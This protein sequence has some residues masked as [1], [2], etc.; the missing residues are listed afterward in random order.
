MAI[1]VLKRVA[2]FICYLLGI[3]IVF[4]ILRVFL[5][6]ICDIFFLRNQYFDPTTRQLLGV[7]VGLWPLLWLAAVFYAARRTLFRRKRGEDLQQKS[8]IEA[9]LA[10]ESS[11]DGR[12]GNTETSHGSDAGLSGLLE[13]LKSGTLSKEELMGKYEMDADT[14]TKHAQVLVAQ[15]SMTSGDYEKLLKPAHL[16][17][18]RPQ[19]RPTSPQRSDALTEATQGAKQPVVN[20]SIATNNSIP[21]PTPKK[22]VS[23]KEVLRDIASGA[24]DVGLMEKYGLSARQLTALYKK[25]E[26][27]GLMK[28]P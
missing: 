19:Q 14:L 4:Q 28:K 22:K 5:V 16:E 21:N 27:A 23:A 17:H 20:R 18:S 6:P 24:D 13:D 25:L 11:S 3:T 8:S 7:V 1:E 2:L 12:G 15:G 26:D 9:V 10:D